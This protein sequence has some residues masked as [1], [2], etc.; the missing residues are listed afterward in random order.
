M[1][2]FVEIESKSIASTIPLVSM[3]SPTC[4]LPNS[5]LSI[6]VSTSAPWV[7]LSANVS[8]TNWS[9]GSLKSFNTSLGNAWLLSLFDALPWCNSVELNFFPLKLFV[10]WEDCS[11]V[12]KL[13]DVASDEIVDLERILFNKNFY[14]EYEDRLN[15]LDVCVVNGNIERIN[16][17]DVWMECVKC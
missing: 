1:P 14:F 17:L 7:L 10:F 4:S 11:D 9:L 16:K 15:D 2:E 5:F 8:S 6:T 13:S 12:G 3:F